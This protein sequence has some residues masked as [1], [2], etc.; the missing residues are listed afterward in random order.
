MRNIFD[1]KL[2]QFFGGIILWGED[3]VSAK[4]ELYIASV[5]KAMR[6]NRSK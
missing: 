5:R 6:V 1:I 3:V 4:M 2:G